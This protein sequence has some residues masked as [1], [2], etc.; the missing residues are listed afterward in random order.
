MTYA[1]IRELAD[2]AAEA[3]PLPKVREYPDDYIGRAHWAREMDRYFAAKDRRARAYERVFD[4]YR[5]TPRT[6]TVRPAPQETSH[7]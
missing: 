7:G 1:D 2:R 3:V 6:P 4:K 5:K